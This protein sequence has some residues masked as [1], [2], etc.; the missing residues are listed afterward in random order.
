M[1]A[2]FED[3]ALNSKLYT[4]CG[5]IRDMYLLVAN[6]KN[7]IAGYS[8]GL[9]DWNCD[10]D[11]YPKP[12]PPTLTEQALLGHLYA[13]TP[14]NAHCGAKANLL[15]KTPGYNDPT[16]TPNY[17]AVKGEFD[18]LQ[19]WKDVLNGDYG[20]WQ[21]NSKSNY[22]Q[23]DPYVA[24]IHG[25]DYLNSPYTYAYS[26]DDAVGNMQ[27]DGTGMIIAVGGPENLPNQDH[28]TPN[29]NFPYGLSSTYPAPTGTITFTKYGRCTTTPNTDPNPNFLSF[30]VP[31]GIAKTPS[32][33]INCQI[34]FSDNLNRHYQFKLKALPPF[35]TNPNPTPAERTAANT[36]FIDCTAN[37]NPQVLN[38]WCV[39]IYPYQMIDPNDKRATI[40]Y[41][42]TIGGPPP[43]K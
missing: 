1:K 15:E 13:W 14:F 38:S 35:P 12:D 27:T 4:I 9:T 22:G 3:C 11:L 18:G 25:K 36:K 5:P 28:A 40:V 39:F 37:T 7:Y 10:V 16:K 29:V 23:F 17:E 34:S 2:L 8:K 42:V 43:I 20:Q 26:V 24:L 32:S 31:E 30:P 41:N 19:Y 33:V 21:D 6:Y